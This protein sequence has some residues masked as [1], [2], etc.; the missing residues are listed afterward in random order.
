MGQ[1]STLMRTHSIP[2]VMS[3]EGHSV[4]NPIDTQ[5]SEG[6]VAGSLYEISYEA[7]RLQLGAPLSTT[8]AGL[9]L[10][11]ECLSDPSVAPADLLFVV[12]RCLNAT[13]SLADSLTSRVEQGQH[14]AA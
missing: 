12:D 6:S 5:T 1:P 11:R 8:L 13:R 4:A 3:A 9:E 14:D 7:F 2:T 10:L